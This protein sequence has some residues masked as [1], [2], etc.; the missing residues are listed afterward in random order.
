M[1]TERDE[2]AMRISA[3][4]A[5]IHDVSFIPYILCSFPFASSTKLYDTYPKWYIGKN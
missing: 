2:L 1:K 4:E 5:K 3:M